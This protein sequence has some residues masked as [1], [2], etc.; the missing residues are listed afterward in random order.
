MNINEYLE[1]NKVIIYRKEYQVKRLT[2]I[3]VCAD[4]FSMSVQASRSHYCSPRE[5]SPIAY[6]SV[7]I[8]FPS[9]EEELI[10]QYAEKPESPTESIYGYVPVKIVDEVI[11]KHGGIVKIMQCTTC[12]KEFTELTNDNACPNCGSGSWVFGNIDSQGLM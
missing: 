2:P 1:K 8:G 11:I 5:D 9:S 4:G 12:E 7:E 6:N 3:L 10:I